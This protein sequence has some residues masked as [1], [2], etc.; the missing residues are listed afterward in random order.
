[1]PSES[2]NPLGLCLCFLFLGILI[3]ISIDAAFRPNHIRLW[4]NPVQDL[5]LRFVPGDTVE[6]YQLSTGK[7]IGITFWGGSPCV[8]AFNPCIIKNIPK[9]ATYYYTCMAADGTICN[10]PQGGPISST[11]DL[12]ALSFFTKISDLVRNVFAP[13]THILSHSPQPGSTG[14]ANAIPAAT[15]STIYAEASCNEPGHSSGV[16]HVTVPGHND[17]DPIHASVGQKILWGTSST[18]DLTISLTDSSTCSSFSSPAKNQYL[19][20]VA[21]SGS[22]TATASPCTPNS[23]ESIAVP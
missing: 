1:M 15:S 3:G 13:L 11:Q 9:T 10:D 2:R 18:G 16:T 7:P 6:W 8:G 21:K 22:Y 19:C 17:D 20:T 23:S 14:A 5:S 4:V 12:E